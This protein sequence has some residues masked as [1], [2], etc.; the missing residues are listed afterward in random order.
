M[1]VILFQ[2][3]RDRDTDDDT[4]SVS[5][6][7]QVIANLSKQLEDQSL[8]LDTL[9]ESE[10]NLRVSLEVAEQRAMEAESK[11]VYAAKRYVVPPLCKARSN[12][13]ISV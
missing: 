1:Y 7:E 9:R 3:K 5:V 10:A 11:L 12:E 6:Y 13:M 2:V 4:D 8:S